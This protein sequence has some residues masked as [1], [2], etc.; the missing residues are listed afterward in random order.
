MNDDTP[1]PYIVFKKID[2]SIS[3]FDNKKDAHN[4]AEG[5][6]AKYPTVLSASVETV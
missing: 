1:T 2:K 3:T 5:L 4:K 6:V